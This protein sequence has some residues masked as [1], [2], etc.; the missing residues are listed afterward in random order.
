MNPPVSPWAEILWVVLGLGLILYAL[1][2]GADLGAGLWSLTASGP[3]KSEQQRTVREAIA[4]IWE[5]NHVWLVFVIV[6]LFSAFPRAFAALGIALHVPI[7]CALVGLVFRG[8]SFS[9]H[10]YG[11]QAE[12]SRERWTRV[13][14][15]SSLITPV[16]LG[17]VIGGLSTGSIRIDESGGVLSG[18]WTGWTSLFSWLVGIFA[19][20]LF[21]ML[22]AT[23][24]AAVTRGELATDF[25]R[26]AVWMEGLTAALAAL[27]FWRS[28]VDAPL[29]F[30][31]LLYSRW[32]LP[33]QAATLVMA[34][35][36]VGLLWKKQ[37]RWA[38]FTAATQ[39]ALIVLGWGLA[40]NGH[41]ILPDLSLANAGSQPT[42]LP[43]LTVALGCGAVLLVPALAYLYWVFH[44]D[45]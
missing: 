28:S 35:A 41:F 1:T 5:A 31:D 12:R 18:Y 3:R 30:R 34:V 27:V 4:P 43:A 17:T 10:A 40:M 21:A 37:A 7:G 36:T 14:A 25:R 32:T 26:R 16:F 11:I 15:W 13:F 9:F 23:Y 22:A 24:L 33:V 45:R 38:R 20:A 6:V 42:V 44:Q 8:A 19:L 29:L 39:T 2:G